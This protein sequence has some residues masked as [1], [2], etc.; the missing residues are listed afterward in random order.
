MEV[1]SMNPSDCPQSSSGLSRRSFFRYAAGA[2]ALASLPILTEAHLA[3]AA[4]PHFADPN[5]GIHID[6]NENP[7]G[8]SGAAAPGDDRHRSQRRTL[9][10]SDGGRTGTDLRQAGRPESRIGDAL[11]RIERAA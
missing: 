7:R 1:L 2:S 3:L 5:K 10:V 11:R 8:P 4:R 9:S 6:A